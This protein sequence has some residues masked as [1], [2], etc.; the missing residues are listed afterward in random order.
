MEK[1]RVGIYVAAIQD[2]MDRKQQQQQPLPK[3][4]S[5]DGGGD[6]D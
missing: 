1:L 4:P 5:G 3:R 2:A 6:K